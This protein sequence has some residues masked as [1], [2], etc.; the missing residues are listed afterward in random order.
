MRAAPLRPPLTLSPSPTSV[1][2]A[3]SLKFIPV[4]MDNQRFHP[5]ELHA[6]QAPYVHL[7]IIKCTSM[8]EYKSTVKPRLKVPPFHV[9]AW[10]PPARAHRA[11]RQAWVEELSQRAGV[12]EYIIVFVP[13]ATTA[14]PKAKDA[15][16]VL[17]RLQGDFNPRGAPNRVCCVHLFDH[18]SDSG[19][20]S[21]S[22]APVRD[23]AGQAGDGYV[24]ARPPR[25]TRDVR[26][27]P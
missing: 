21:I 8:Q 20:G 19:R 25:P 5:S 7:S 16:K 1:L 23:G 24:L 15:K 18:P 10:P 3:P 4:S 9:H 12:E 26:A 27:L 2:R 22:G 17:D 11:P 13:L 14:Q 6:T